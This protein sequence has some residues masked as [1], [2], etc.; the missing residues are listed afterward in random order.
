MN[1]PATKT[2][3]TIPRDDEIKEFTANSI[4]KTLAQNIQEK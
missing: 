3:I 1:K 2:E 4:I